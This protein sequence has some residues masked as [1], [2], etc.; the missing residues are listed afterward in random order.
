MNLDCRPLGDEQQYIITITS[1]NKD[2]DRKCGLHMTQFTGQSVTQLTRQLIIL[3][4]AY[5]GYYRLTADSVIFCRYQWHTTASCSGHQVQDTIFWH[6]D[7]LTEYFISSTIISQHAHY[8]GYKMLLSVSRMT[9]ALSAKAFSVSAPSLWN[10][11]SYNCRSAQLLSTF[12]RNLKHQNFW[13]C[14]Q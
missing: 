4:Y 11:Q 8:V 14:L 5:A 9:L 13:H 3:Q 7:G 1:R 6:L 10:S 12:R 2:G